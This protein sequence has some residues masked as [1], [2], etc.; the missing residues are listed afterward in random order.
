MKKC[1]CLN[2]TVLGKP[3]IYLHLYALAHVAGKLKC[4]YIRLIK[5]VAINQRLIKVAS[6]QRIYESSEVRFYTTG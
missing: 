6:T 3:L 1:L 4:T 2:E 5:T